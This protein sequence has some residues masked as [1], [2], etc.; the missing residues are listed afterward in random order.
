MRDAREDWRHFNAAMIPSKEATPHLDGFLATMLDPAPTPPPKAVLDVGC[1][2]GR[3]AGRLY[4]RGYSVLGVD[5]SPAAIRL[6][7]GLAVPAATGRWLRFVEADFASERCPRLDGGPFDLV[8]CHLVISIIGNVDNRRN[9]LRHARANLRPDGWL[10]LSASGVSDTINPGYARLYAEDGQVTGER[11]SYLSRDERGGI[12]YMTHHFTA[13]ELSS[14][15][16]EAGFGRISVTTERETSSRRP[17]EAAFFH[18]VTCRAEVR[19]A[20]SGKSGTG[21]DFDVPAR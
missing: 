1:G 5:I 20:R 10:Y 18:H 16:A 21:A 3:L 4:A 2:S 6:A 15:L 19:G 13:D 12:L 14:L 11:H 7:R 17:N 9:L 8:V